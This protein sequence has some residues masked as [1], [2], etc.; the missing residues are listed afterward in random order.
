MPDGEVLNS[1]AA[2]LR[3]T[4]SR[5]PPPRDVAGAFATEAFIARTAASGGTVDDEG[6]AT[7][8]A[9]CKKVEVVRRVCVA[10]SADLARVVDRSPV[11]GDHA[12]VLC[13]VYLAAAAARRDPKLLN[14][15]M[16][17]LDGC[18]KEPSPEAPSCLRQWAGRMLDA[19]P[20]LAA[21]RNE[22]LPQ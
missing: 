14:T 3:E 18:L 20:W 10:Y 21:A 17:M 4:A 11:T 19:W 9:L 22:V 16:K 5:L 13:G 6:A 7:L 15:A 1:V 8:D 12:T 2:W